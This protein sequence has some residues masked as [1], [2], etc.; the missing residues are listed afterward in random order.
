MQLT[1][2]GLAAGT[3]Y[4]GSVAYATKKWADA[5]DPT[6]EPRAFRQRGRR[7]ERIE[8][9]LGA[10]EREIDAGLRQGVLNL[11]RDRSGGA[12]EIT[13]VVGHVDDGGDAAGG[14]RAGRPGEALLVLLAQRMH[15]RIDG[16]RQDQRVAQLVA[17]GCGRV[18]EHP[19][20]MKGVLESTLA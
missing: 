8:I 18:L 12:D 17:L 1:F 20:W 7:A 5:H 14:G 16:A 10:V 11:P 19:K 15:L 4:L 2:T 3:K 9:R 6:D 13:L